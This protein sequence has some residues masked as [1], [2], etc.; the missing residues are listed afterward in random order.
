MTAVWPDAFDVDVL[1]R[2]CPWMLAELA[3]RIIALAVAGLLA[4]LGPARPVGLVV[5]ALVVVPVLAAVSAVAWSAPFGADSMMTG[6]PWR[7]REAPN[8]AGRV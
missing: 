2:F 8:G 3:A 1:R 4:A 6:P 7:A 5:L